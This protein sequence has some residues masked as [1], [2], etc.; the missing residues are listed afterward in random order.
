[1][2]CAIANSDGSLAGLRVPERHGKQ[3]PRQVTVDLTNFR[4][5]NPSERLLLF[6]AAPGQLANGHAFGVLNVVGVSD[7][8]VYRLIY[9]DD[10]TGDIFLAVP[11]PTTFARTAFGLIGL[12]VKRRRW[13][14]P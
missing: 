5:L 10:A 3:W 11:E 7:P 13:P 1:M 14:R 8:S 2:A 12:V 9:D 6:D 4:E